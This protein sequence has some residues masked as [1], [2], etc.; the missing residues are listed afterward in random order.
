M[1]CM[2]IFSKWNAA[3]FPTYL[4]SRISLDFDSWWFIICFAAFV[5]TACFWARL[6]GVE[7]RFSDSRRNEELNLL[8]KG[9]I[10]LSESKKVPWGCKTDIFDINFRFW[11]FYRDTVVVIRRHVVILIRTRVKIGRIFIIV[12]LRNELC[13]KL[14]IEYKTWKWEGYL[15]PNDIVPFDTG[16]IGMLFDFFWGRETATSILIK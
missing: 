6:V 4:E 12:Q 9:L 14:G 15:L 3:I 8:L 2:P 11:A 7:S 16:K 13:L 10:N 1:P 5:L